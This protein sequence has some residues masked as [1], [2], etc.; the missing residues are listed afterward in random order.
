M[1]KLTL[2][3]LNKYDIVGLFTCFTFKQ[4]QQFYSKQLTVSCFYLCSSTEK[5]KQTKPFKVHQK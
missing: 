3:L 1:A 4:K 2:H 5:N